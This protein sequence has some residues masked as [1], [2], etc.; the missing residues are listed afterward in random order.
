MS[1]VKVTA[2]SIGGGNHIANTKFNKSRDVSNKNINAVNNDLTYEDI[3][4]PPYDFTELADLIE[5]SNMLPQCIQAMEQN[6]EGFGYNLVELVQEEDKEKLKDEMAEEKKRVKFFFEYCNYD[7]SFTELRKKLR[8]DYESFGVCFIEVLRNSAGNVDGFEYIKAY[9]MRLSRLSKRINVKMKKLDKENYEYETVDYKKKFR[10]FIQVVGK[11]KVYFK[12]FGDPRKIDSETGEE[13]TEEY[14][15]DKNKKI[16]DIVFATEIIYR[17]NESVKSC[18]GLPR[19][20]GNTPSV[21]GSRLAEEVNYD[22]FNEKTVPPMLIAVS[23]G[24]LTKGAT[25]RIKEHFKGI[26]GKDNFHKVLILEAEGS[27]DPNVLEKGNVKIDVKELSQVGEAKFIEYDKENRKKVRSAFRLPELYTGENDQNTYASVKSMKEIAE[28]QV[29]A[30]E[31][32]NFDFVI[33]RKIFPDLD[34]KFHSFQTKSAPIDN[35]KER[36]EFLK[37][38]ADAGLTY[39]DARNQI[40]GLLETEITKIDDM[41]ANMPIKL[42]P[43]LLQLIK[44]EAQAKEQTSSSKEEK[45]AM[46]DLVEKLVKV[47]KEL[48]KKIDENNEAA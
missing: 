5:I 29:F 18:Y 35:S 22:Y 20:I 47:R 42:A 27:Q 28:E 31:K 14:L 40:A 23:G 13:V 48:I 12:E 11:D 46:N 34:V 41:Y 9:T 26:K 39:E 38:L 21:G 37:I 4:E 30:P 44:A 15:K 45:S 19:W 36:A 16:E 25:S 43:H 17:A 8:K 10:L 1:D 7:M 6:C 3:I 24:T 32:Q 2:I 33:N